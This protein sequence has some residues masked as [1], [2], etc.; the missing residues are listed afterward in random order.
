MRIVDDAGKE[1]PWDGKAFGNLQVPALCH[2]WEG[3]Y[4]CCILC[5][6]WAMVWKCVFGRGRVQSGLHAVVSCSKAWRGSVGP[7]G[8]RVVDAAG[9]RQ[10]ARLH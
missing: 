4:L 1:L 6:W 7:A 9:W 8:R 3:E 5:S 10:V 2:G